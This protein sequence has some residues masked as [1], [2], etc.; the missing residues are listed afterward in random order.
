M[1][2]GAI[3]LF[4]QVVVFGKTKMGASWVRRL[5]DSSPKKKGFMAI[6]G[7][8]HSDVSKVMVPAIISEFPPSHKP[9]YVENAGEIR[10]KNGALIHAY[11]SDQ[12]IRGGNYEYVWC[13]E[14]VK[15]CDSIPSKIDERF[16]TLDAGCRIGQAKFLITTTPKPFP[17]FKKWEKMASE[18]H[19][20]VVMVSGSMAE[21]DALS[22]HAKD[23]L[24]EQ[25][26]GTRMGRQEL[27]GELLT[28][29]EGAL[30][31]PNYFDDNRV[32]P[33]EVP[34]VLRTVV[35]IDPAVSTNKNSDET[36]II[37]AS[38]CDDMNV[39]V[40]ADSSG[41]YTPSQWAKKVIALYKQYKADR[42]IA[43]KNQG[44]ALVKANLDA[45]GGRNL[46]YK[47][48]H[49]TKGKITRAE[50]VAALYEQGR[51]KHIGNFNALEDQCC[52]YGP[53]TQVSPDRMDALVYAIT[54]LLLT[55]NVVRRSTDHVP[56]F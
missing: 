56:Q 46:P 9:V 25:Y 52:Q 41:V 7:P 53:G 27:D 12:E 38:L 47:A 42:I 3:A 14:M 4:A 11:S 19:K 45:N 8:S 1:V 22:Q 33:T 43:E 17:I 48:I 6:V 40:Q 50:P 26:G 37:V 28:D 13:D 2:I 18:N 20:L 24:Y 15:W 49:A 55:A 39:Y 51:V 21:N 30:W 44:G 16:K 35:A 29:T 23:A 31:K 34:S 10:F 32:K 36:A 5:V 54:E